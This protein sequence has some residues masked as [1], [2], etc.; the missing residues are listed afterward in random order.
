MQHFHRLLP[1]A[2]S[3]VLKPE[4]RASATL[5]RERA[6]A[7]LK[8]CSE[9][10]LERGL[11]LIG[12][13]GSYDAIL[14]LELEAPWTARLIGSRASDPALDAA[15]ESIAQSPRRI[16]LLAIEP[17]GGRTS[18]RVLWFEATQA[19]GPAFARRE[20]E[21]ERARLAETVTALAATGSAR[22]EIGCPQG[23]RDILV[24]TH[25]ARDACCGKFGFPLY[26]RFV[27]LAAQSAAAPLRIRR[28]SHLGGHRFAPTLLDLPSGRL[29]GRV[30]ISDAAVILDGAEALLQRLATIYRGRCS[31]P[32]AA[33]I[34]ERQLWMEVGADFEPALLSC[35]LESRRDQ[36]TV[37]L[38]MRQSGGRSRSLHAQVVRAELD[39]VVTPASCGRDPEPEAPWRIIS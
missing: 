29:Y 22:G 26:S 34:V 1:G 21:V 24:C 10:S 36:W 23:S 39:A 12:S 17:E 16:R 13:A 4:E 11:P 19:G 27:E 28:C 7:T 6:S 20:F 33:Q 30:A 38:T 25:G 15:I 32:E 9:L 3:S 5:S 8:L 14:A 37:R 2:G 18:R 35:E 31:L